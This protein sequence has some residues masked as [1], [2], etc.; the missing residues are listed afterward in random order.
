MSEFPRR[1]DARQGA[2]VARLVQ[3]RKVWDLGAGSGQLAAWLCDQGAAAVEAVDRDYAPPRCAPGLVRPGLSFTAGRFDSWEPAFSADVAFL[4]W[5][6]NWAV[7]GLVQCLRRVPTC[8][9]VGLNQRVSACGGPDLWSAL[10]CRE[11]LLDIP[12]KW[13]NLLVYGKR[14]S[15]RL[16][17]ADE[18]RAALENW[19]VDP[20][21]LEEILALRVYLPATGS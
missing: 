5:P 1:L 2:E 16:P 7:S 21:V 20:R 12:G 13:G 8:I 3:G 19:N 9:Y 17:A 6:V 18:E 11:L 4:S 15:P 10:L 14:C